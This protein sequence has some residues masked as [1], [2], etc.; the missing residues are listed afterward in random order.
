MKL[1]WLTFGI[2]SIILLVLE[3]SLLFLPPFNK[4][5]FK[6]VRRYKG[7]VKVIGKKYD[8]KKLLYI[9]S[10]KASRNGFYRFYSLKDYSVGNEVWVDIMEESY[11]RSK[12][13]FGLT[14]IQKNK[15]GLPVLEIYSTEQLNPAYKQIVGFEKS[16]GSLW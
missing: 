6:S 5:I 1:L 7:M 14:L 3:L 16:N 2:L 10:V 12:E 13:V 9:Y 15:Q 4:R 11:Y 8:S